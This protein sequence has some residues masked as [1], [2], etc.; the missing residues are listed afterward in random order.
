VDGLDDYDARRPLTPTGTNILGLIKYLSGVETSRL[1]E[2]VE[3]P[4]T[5][6]LP[7]VEDGSIWDGADMRAAADQSRDH[8][9]G[10]YHE[11]WTHSNT[12]ISGLP[13]DAPAC[14]SSWP[15]ERRETTL[16]HL[17]VRVV[18]ETAQHAGHI[19]IL[20]ESIDGQAGGDHDDIGDAEYWARYVAQI[21][22]AADACRR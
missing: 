16:G 9:V 3:R 10:L 22:A 12:S 2:C 5:V 11:A 18:A 6:R 15:A 13:L 8:I 17:V 1:G 19:D 4:S 14:V 21:Q 7:W 20:R